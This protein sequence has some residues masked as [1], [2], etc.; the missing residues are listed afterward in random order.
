MSARYEKYGR[1][2]RVGE[3]HAAGAEGHLEVRLVDL[4]AALGALGVVGV[5]L[6]K[7]APRQRPPRAHLEPDARVR[8]LHLRVSFNVR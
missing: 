7:E 8:A 5:A 2:D 4:A 3:E 6:D 1:T